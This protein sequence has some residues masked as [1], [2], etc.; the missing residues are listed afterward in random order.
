MMAWLYGLLWALF[1]L[2]REKEQT[3]WRGRIRAHM[4]EQ[5]GRH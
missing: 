5:Y 2:Q 3:E 4:M 1:D